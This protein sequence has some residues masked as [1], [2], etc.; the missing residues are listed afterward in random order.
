MTAC[1]NLLCL[2]RV[3]AALSLLLSVG[4]GRGQDEIF[5]ILVKLLHSWPQKGAKVSFW[6]S[7]FFLTPVSCTPILIRVGSTK[8]WQRL[9]DTSRSGT[10]WLGL[11][12]SA[13]H[14]WSW[15]VAGQCAIC[16]PLKLTRVEPNL[17]S[18]VG[19]F[20]QDSTLVTRAELNPD[21]TCCNHWLELLIQNTDCSCSKVNACIAINWLFPYTSRKWV[22]ALP[23]SAW[24]A[25]HCTSL[26]ITLRIPPVPRV[27]LTTSLGNTYLTPSHSE[28]AG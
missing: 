10:L 7:Y 1:T 28:P 5:F 6:H 12:H 20:E 16:S 17:T 15:F 27:C 22:W 11:R 14:H 25:P 13:W 8:T 21:K 19:T 23:H 18:I 26:P 3:L 9:L 24:R 4:W 2:S